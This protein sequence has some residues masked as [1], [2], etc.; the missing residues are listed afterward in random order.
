[1]IFYPKLKSLKTLKDSKI[2]GFKDYLD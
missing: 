1:M 2:E